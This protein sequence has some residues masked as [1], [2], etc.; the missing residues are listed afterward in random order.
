MTRKTTTAASA[1]NADAPDKTA[2][3]LE[4]ATEEPRG[5]A[6]VGTPP[7]TGNDGL[8][9]QV[10]EGKPSPT[11]PTSNDEASSRVQTVREPCRVIVL[12]PKQ[13]RRR[14]GRTFGPEP[15]ILD[16]NDLSDAEAEALGEDP[17]L[18]VSFS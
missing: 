12:G 16:L 5:T 1:Q 13:G 17:D 9:E 15:T 2:I 7:T 11:L 18:V 3:E 4:P 8:A 14:I 6:G 10:G